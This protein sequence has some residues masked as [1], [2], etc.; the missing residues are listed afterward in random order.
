MFDLVRLY[1]RFSNTRGA[2]RAGATGGTSMIPV[3]DIRFTT[4]VNRWL[5]VPD[6]YILWL[7]PALNMARNTLPKGTFRPGVLP[8]WILARM[9]CWAASLA[10]EFNIPTVIEYRDLWTGN[11]YA[12]L[13]QPTAMHRAV[14]GKIERR[15]PFPRLSI[16][17]CFARHR[18]LLKEDLSP[19]KQPPELR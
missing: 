17:L 11:P 14:H 5:M 8:R 1:R 13:D 18:R 9:S 19:R 2:S 7:K 15:G 6:K 4:F 10:R 3:R 12:H 16:N